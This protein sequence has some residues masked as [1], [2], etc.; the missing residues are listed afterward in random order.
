M[1][2]AA[3]FALARSRWMLAN[4]ADLSAANAWPTFAV[5]SACTAMYSITLG[6]ST[7]A[8]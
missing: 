7:S 6:K 4:T 5:Q 1:R 3:A 8:T 2:I